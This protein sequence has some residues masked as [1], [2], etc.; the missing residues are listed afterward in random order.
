MDAFK[1]FKKYKK[2]RTSIK[3]KGKYTLWVAD[4]PAKKTIGL[5]RV[6]Q[7]PKRHGMIFIYNEDVDGAFTMKNTSIPLQIIFLDVNF[8]VVDSFIC[9]PYDKKSVQPSTSY[10]YVI[11]I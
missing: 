9:R 2:I 11:E 7:L 5:S 1:L 3:G 8:N 10:R 4:T 6:S